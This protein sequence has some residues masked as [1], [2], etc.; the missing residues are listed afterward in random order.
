MKSVPL[1]QCGILTITLAITLAAHSAFADFTVPLKS[2]V[3]D[4]NTTDWNEINSFITDAEG[5]VTG[6][7]RMDITSAYIAQDNTNLYFRVTFANDFGNVAIPWFQCSFHG[8]ANSTDSKDIQF[9][10]DIHG[11]TAVVSILTDIVGTGENETIMAYA[12]TDNFAK[13]KDYTLEFKVLKEHVTVDLDN[14]SFEVH[15][16]DH[17]LGVGDATGIETIRLPGFAPTEDTYEWFPPEIFNVP[18]SSIT[19]DGNVSDWSTL[20]VFVE[21]RIGELYSVGSRVD[22]V[23]AYM[24][25]DS[26]YLYFRVDINRDISTIVN[27][28]FSLNFFT[29]PLIT[30]EPF[31]SF[32]IDFAGTNITT[33]I[34][35]ST[36]EN[37][38]NVV[39]TYSQASGY[40][41]MF[42]THLEFKVNIADIPFSISEHEIEV[43]T[44]DHE[45]GI[46][47]N[48][49]K[50]KVALD[51]W[52]PAV[53]GK[54]TTSFA[55]HESL[56]VSNATVSIHDT[57]LT[58]Y[59][60]NNGIFLFAEIPEGSYTMAIEAAGLRTLLTEISVNNS[61]RLELFDIPRMIPGVAS[62]TLFDV[63][64]DGVTG[65][66]EA[67]YALRSL[68]EQSSVKDSDGDGF[69]VGE[70][71]CDDSNALIYPGAIESCN[72]EDDNCNGQI[73]EQ[74]GTIYYQDNDNDGY[75][76]ASVATQSCST[77]P[78]AGYA[79]SDQDCNDSD[80]NS[81]PGANEIP[82]DGIDQ[83]CDGSD[84]I[85]SSAAGRYFLVVGPD[86]FS[87]QYAGV[88]I[89]NSDGTTS[90]SDTWSQNGSSVTIMS[91]DST[92][93][94]CVFTSGDNIGM[95]G[96]YGSSS[97]WSAAS[98]EGYDENNIQEIMDAV[99]WAIDN[100]DQCN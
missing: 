47:D 39:A 70:G 41:A 95:A 59:T 49:P 8:L 88:I 36:P 78:P 13:L 40:A 69:L 90:G 24:A 64:N 48:T 2:I 27:P 67:I 38:K 65:I 15:A 81:H 96:T 87:Y 60:D 76:T 62:G 1:V 58:S 5:D 28:W 4:G 77:T 55:G 79:V 33:T 54:I 52:N 32:A 61:H 23:N 14:M 82:N 92:F 51:S 7:E 84:L 63:D 73:D 30:S 50:V 89:L 37:G 97:C 44:Y 3:I 31:L 45:Y 9:R 29:W 11:T 71:D 74:A 85:N 72:N 93:Q 98:T 16:Y 20:P 35:S 83:D 25:K 57:E 100:K 56:P 6:G 21:D 12:D 34:E 53:I 66:A 19:I 68:T 10:V 18:D 42:G 86:C 17:E 75:G 80:V 43:R 46:G 26:E 94:G 91:G 22:I 99:S